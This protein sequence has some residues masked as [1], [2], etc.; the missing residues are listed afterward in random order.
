[1]TFLVIAI[2]GL[3]IFLCGAVASWLWVRA[4]GSDSLV[5]RL[6]LG[7]SVFFLLVGLLVAAD[8]TV[9]TYRFNKYVDTSLLRDANQERCSQETLAALR[10]WAEA[11][12]H[13]EDAKTQRDHALIP[14]F[15]QLIRGEKTHPDT[16]LGVQRAITHV[17]EERAIMNQ[18]LNEHPIPNCQLGPVN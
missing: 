12:S 18:K 5:K 15:D 3:A 13:V 17:E 11:R 10:V 7:L 14:L 2:I 6:N 9:L 1:M 8:I 4:R 16:A